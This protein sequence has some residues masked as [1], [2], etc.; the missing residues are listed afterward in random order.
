M[1]EMRLRHNKLCLL[2]QKADD[3]FSLTSGAI[4]IFNSAAMLLC[5]YLL[6]ADENLRSDPLF[7]LMQLIWVAMDIFSLGMMAIRRSFV[8][9]EVGIIDTTQSYRITLVGKT[10]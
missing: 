7:L 10:K 4:Y 6:V 5:L 3:F 2:V 8:K 1:E 9:E